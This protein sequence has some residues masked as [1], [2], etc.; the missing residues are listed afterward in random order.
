MPK[1]KPPKPSKG[2]YSYSRRSRSNPKKSRA[3]ARAEA[4]R[5]EDSDHNKQLAA[6]RQAQAAQRRAE[7]Q[8]KMREAERKARTD[9]IESARKRAERHLSRDT[10]DSS[11]TRPRTTIR[12]PR[13]VDTSSVQR[14]AQ[15]QR[16][17][18]EAERK[19]R[20]LMDFER[21]RD[22]AHRIGVHRGSPHT[23]SP[24]P[25]TKVGAPIFAQ[26]KET[27]DNLGPPRLDRTRYQFPDRQTRT[28]QYA[29]S[30]GQQRQFRTY[31]GSRGIPRPEPQVWPGAGYTPSQG[32]PRPPS[33][34]YTPSRQLGVG[35]GP[36]VDYSPSEG[37]QRQFNTYEGSRGIPRPDPQVWPGAGYTPSRGIPNPGAT[38][39]SPST[40][41]GA[42]PGTPTTGQP[43]GGTEKE[44]QQ[45]AQE[46]AKQ[47]G[48]QPVV[49]T[50][51]QENPKMTREQL[52]EEM[53]QEENTGGVQR[54]FGLQGLQNVLQRIDRGLT[55]F[56]GTNPDQFTPEYREEQ[57]R[58]ESIRQAE[59]DR[60][61][62]RKR[63]E[64][65]GQGQGVTKEQEAEDAEQ[66][67][68]DDAVSRLS[69]EVRE[70]YEIMADGLSNEQKIEILKSLLLIPGV[71]P[72]NP[73]QVQEPAQQ[74]GLSPPPPPTR[75]QP[76]LFTEWGGT[77]YSNPYV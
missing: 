77:P 17:I 65:Q 34:Q 31:E 39:Y 38:Q 32:I 7:A 27:L 53:M 50:G 42:K 47:A 26:Q 49:S 19:R 20:E 36:G 21:R 64:G 37:S 74:V 68:I 25:A 12:T 55:N 71:V 5:R 6:R 33:R 66:F 48:L 72:Q 16:D 60:E 61:A 54:G 11:P 35:P 22:E 52:Q 4:Q 46:I 29:P 62:I 56:F 15:A 45:V 63:Q 10:P 76:R 73:T 70:I 59:A 9:L 44:A 18:M 75:V 23:P 24:V 43:Q 67:S 1:G 30:Q 2:K 13:R 57:A 69:P 14:R 58:L 40:Q 41:L 8:R 28:N 51:V 3:Q